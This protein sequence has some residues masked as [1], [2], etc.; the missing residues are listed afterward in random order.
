MGKNELLKTMAVYYA[1]L[2]LRVVP[3]HGVYGRLCTCNNPAC[4]SPAKHPRTINGL[5]D[6]SA[7]AEVVERMWTRWPFASIGICTGTDSGVLVI[8][9]DD[10]QQVPDVLREWA[11]AEHPPTWRA[12]TGRGG[13]HV[14][15]RYDADRGGIRSR[16][17]VWPKVDVRA[18]GGY[19]VAAPSPHVNGNTYCWDPG[20]APADTELARLPEAIEQVLRAGG[21]T[22]VEQPAFVA[23]AP[24]GAAAR[25]VAPSMLPKPGAMRLHDD[26][27]ARIRAAL[28]FI[29]A[30]GR[31]EWLYVGM[32]LKSTSAGRQAFDIWTEWS[33]TV[34]HKFNADDQ[35]KTWQGLKELL[36]SGE[37]ITIR[38][39][40]WMAQ[41]A[42][43]PDFAGVDVEVIDV[44]I[45]EAPP[46]P[47][48]APAPEPEPI[49]NQPGDGAEPV[50][51]SLVEP[52]DPRFWP[53]L[54][55]RSELLSEMV[56]WITKTA[57]KKQPLLAFGNSLAAV[58]ALLGRRVRSPGNCRTN[59]YVFGIA[60]SGRGKEQSR[61]CISQLFAAAG[62]THWIGADKWK[63][64]SGVRAELLKSPAHLAQID[65]FGKVLAQVASPYA[66][67]HLAGIVQT[68]LELTGRAGGVDLGP[69][70]ADQK[71]RPR[72]VI[73]EPCLA[74]Y[75]TA[76]PNDVFA[77]LSSRS[78][79]DGFLN[80]WICLF[81]DD[82]PTIEERE[83]ASYQ[84]PKHLVEGLQLLEQN[85][86][87]QASPAGPQLNVPS[88]APA[89]HVI[90]RTDDASLRR[91]DIGRA[92]ERES[93]AKEARGDQLADL[94]AR[95]PELIEKVALV[96]AATRP[97]RFELRDGATVA[98]WDGAP[99]RAAG[100]DADG[101]AV[102]ARVP[103][104]IEADDVDLAHD[105][106]A[107]CFRRFE[108][109][110]G[111]RVADTE[112]EA[113]LKRVLRTIIGAGTRG[114]AQNEFTRKTQWMS[115]RE[116]E[117]VAKTLAESGQIVATVAV[118]PKGGK[119]VTTFRFAGFKPPETGRQRSSTGRQGVEADQS[120]AA[121]A[122]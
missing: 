65:E 73:I 10:L 74:L 34:P 4:R 16:T 55:Q 25:G 35:A 82:R 117:D 57:P 112:Y 58:G 107:W 98:K 48:E 3:L 78:V 121:V 122:T 54:K 109:E 102:E 32:A 70:Y 118:P 9:L 45:L 23:S 113:K 43:A 93:L 61:Q 39:L 21:G 15:F 1:G 49:E 6:G 110:V 90:P 100:K 50:P 105:L 106:V 7:E 96:F 44:K 68:L 87:T 26:E 104:T 62:L 67:P 69:A 66:P 42:G 115:S 46:V 120:D 64:D 119:P 89:A 79:A 17:G 37:E 33:Q 24:G 92:I 30:T 80:R 111:S 53:R 56:D 83:D 18:D 38:K 116:R 20:C 22:V 77:S 5:K 101:F 84:P 2:G 51:T 76:V 28:A 12:T 97:V 59:L 75:A 94:W 103:C 27:V 63:S 14:F 13:K 85:W 52:M 71:Q 8:D 99:A 19:V 11:L 91:R 36:P 86:R 47:A 60:P 31:T 41:K 40:Y 88:M 81:G 114:I 108:A 29:D 72:E 95:V